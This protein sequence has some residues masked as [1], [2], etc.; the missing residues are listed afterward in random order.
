MKVSLILV[1]IAASVSIAVAA[2]NNESS[3]PR[4]RYLKADKSTKVSKSS[5]TKS[6]K[7]KPSKSSTLEPECTADTVEINCSEFI[8]PTAVSW[9][10]VT[11][12]MGCV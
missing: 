5:N 9:A 12:M 11:L 3:S 8:V 2:V 6:S 1:I 4:H 7:S 10:L